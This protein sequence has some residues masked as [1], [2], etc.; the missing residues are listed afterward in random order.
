[1]LEFKTS[2]AALTMFILC[3][4]ISGKPLVRAFP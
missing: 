4:P 1:M 3:A 2:I